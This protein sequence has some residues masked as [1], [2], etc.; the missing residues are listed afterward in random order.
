[1]Q[2]CAIVPTTAPMHRL[3]RDWQDRHTHQRVWALATPMIL[4]NLSVPL[5]GLV[6]SMVAGHLAHAQQ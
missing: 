1:M 5:V 6:D 3:L 4:S 2:E